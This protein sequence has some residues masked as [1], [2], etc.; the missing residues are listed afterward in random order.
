MNVRLILALILMAPATAAAQGTPVQNPLELPE[1]GHVREQVAQIT[2]TVRLRV[3]EREYVRSADDDAIVAAGLAALRLWE[4]TGDRIHA[5]RSRSHF[6]RAARSDSRNAWAHYGH[7]LSLAAEMNR[8]PS[9]VVTH[10]NASRDLGLDPVSR[11]RRALERAVALDPSLPGALDLLADYSITTRDEDGLILARTSFEMSAGSAGAS[12]TDLL[13]IAT[14]SGALGDIR[15]AVAAA[16][17]AVAASD[18][19]ASAYLAL[20]V[21]LAAWPDSLAPAGVAYGSA[22][23][24]ADASMLDRMWDDA[25]MVRTQD[26]SAQWH[27][28]DPMR[29]RE[30]LRAFWDV[31]GAL[32]G[33][34]GDE[35]AAEHYRRVAIAKHRF[36]RRGMFGAPPGNA[37]VL[38]KVSAEFDDR[39]VIY[40]RH[41]EPEHTIGEPPL[42]EHIAWFYSDAGGSPRSYHFEKKATG[43]SRDYLLMYNLPCA[44][45]P[46]AATFDPR[47]TP[48]VKPYCDWMTVRSVSATL[49]R[50]AHHALRSDSHNPTF[51]AAIPFY[52][53]F[54]SFRADTGT[55]LLMAV[56]VPLD[57]LPPGQR[58]LR[59][60]LSVI[61]TA[62]A[63]TAHTSRITELLERSTIP[64]SV[65]RTHLSVLAAPANGIY[66]IDLRDASDPR[67]GTI[68][69]GDI[70]LPD[71]TADTLMVSDIVLA[72][73][74]DDGNVQRGDVRLALSPTQVFS[75][76]EF[77]VYYEIYNLAPGTAYSTELI[78]EP[79]RDGIGDRLRRLFSADDNVE[80]RFDD[81][82]PLEAGSTL[83]QLRDVTAPFRAGEWRMRIT[84]STDNGRI[85]RERRFTIEER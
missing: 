71:Y 47:L 16:R 63:T 59:L 33:L 11:A 57:R 18:A 27:D 54:Y 26:D 84:I 64:H 32:A 15:G 69:G 8:E 68:H 53:D 85:S 19:S 72:E 21:S 31:R 46:M 79:V 66:R 9:R 80:L 22:L 17:R 75:N 6:D 28:S 13:G 4:V 2:D 39:G 78:I 81:T 82:V 43:P 52:Y 65:L 5:R 42:N 55:E 20:A 14:T 36:H 40:V 38:E 70:E 51:I 3:L 61:D 76:G 23:R 37:L 67:I 41:G 73:Q 34:T 49:G 12:E 29:R 45:D 60:R 30:L 50:D 1:P 10:I 44:M 74:R 58:S 62:L 25:G 77:R 56:G 48:L 7:A 35:R 83:P 24:L